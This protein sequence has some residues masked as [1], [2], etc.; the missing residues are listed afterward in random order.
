M[1]APARLDAPPTAEPPDLMTVG[2]TIV[3]LRLDVDG[4]DA[5]ERLRSLVR[6]QGLPRLKRGRLILYRRADIDAWLSGETSG[7]RSR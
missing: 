2:E 7:R 6:Y 4:R 3:Y 5:H 1:I